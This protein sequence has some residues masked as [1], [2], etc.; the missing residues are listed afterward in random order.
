[1][2]RI[3]DGLFAGVLL[4]SAC[5]AQAPARLEFEAASVKPAS[6]DPKGFMV[7]FHGG[8]GFPDPTLFRC[9]NYSLSNL[10]N[11]AYALGPNDLS[12]PD[13][14]QATLFNVDARVPEGAT[15]DQFRVMLQNLLADR[16]KLAVH[17]ETRESVEY[18]LVVAKGGPKFK[19][20][21]KVQQE[22]PKADDGAPPVPKPLKLNADGYPAFEPGKGGVA[23]S[24]GRA[25]MSL[26]RETMSGLAG[27]LSAYLHTHVT[28]ATGLAGEFAIDLYWVMDEGPS[29]GADETPGPTLVEAVQKQLG[30]RLEK[31]ANGT[32]DVLVVDHAEKVPTGN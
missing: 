12:A 15:Q 23:V 26:Q 25:R 32:K 2:M 11:W 16:F 5:Y 14:A 27:Q 22:E 13:W 4:V 10:I 24:R 19:A 18:R 20:A 31:T 28:E 30:L 3:L 1:M 21:A 6:P 7:S 8:P 17:H 9:E 29:A